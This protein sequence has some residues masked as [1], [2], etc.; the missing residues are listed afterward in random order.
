[1]PVNYMD[2]FRYRVTAAIERIA[3][4][5]PSC[6]ILMVPHPDDAHHQSTYPQPKFNMQELIPEFMY[7]ASGL[8]CLDTI[9]DGI[10]CT[11]TCAST[12]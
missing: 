11:Q 4:E 8:D 2:L 7:D 12:M 5:C 9:Q 3:P 6:Q 10:A 1:M